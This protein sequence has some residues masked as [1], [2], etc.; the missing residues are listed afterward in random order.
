MKGRGPS[1]CLHFCPELSVVDTIVSSPVRTSVPEFT[2]TF[3]GKSPSCCLDNGSKW[4]ATKQG[5]GQL[6]S[7]NQRHGIDHV[8]RQR[9]GEHFTATFNPGHPFCLGT[10]NYT[11]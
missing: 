6:S 7:V 4:K 11:M 2:L 1:S 10:R 8:G 9:L 3:T 5:V